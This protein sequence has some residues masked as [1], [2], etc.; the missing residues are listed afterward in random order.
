MNGTKLFVFHNFHAKRRRTISEAGHW[1]GVR[2]VSSLDTSKAEVLHQIR[3][4]QEVLHSRQSLSETSSL[5]DAKWDV[6]II[7][8]VFPLRSDESLGSEHVWVPPVA[9]IH[10]DRVGRGQNAGIRRNVILAHCNRTR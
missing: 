1:P 9:L 2:G 8:S 3:K 7:R 10:V 4:K 6:S 5:S